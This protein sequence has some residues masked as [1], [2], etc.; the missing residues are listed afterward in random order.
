MLEL[1]GNQE[2]IMNRTDVLQFLHFFFGNHA[3][4][5]RQK[6][7]VAAGLYDPQGAWASMM[8]ED[9]DD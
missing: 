7:G 2:S 3:E 9:D 8:K 5:A 4:T 1:A 6:A